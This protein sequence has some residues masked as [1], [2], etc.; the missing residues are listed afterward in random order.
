MGSPAALQ[1]DPS[2]EA[3][4]E[5]EA[6][7]ENSNLHGARPVYQN[8]SMRKWIRTSRLSIKNSLCTPWGRR[9]RCSRNRA[10][11]R[12]ARGRRRTRSTQIRSPAFVSRVSGFGFR[13]SGFGL[14]VSG[15]GFRVS[16][17]GFRVLDF[18]FRL[19]VLW[20]RVSGFGFCVSGF[21]FRVLG[22]EPVGVLAHVVGVHHDQRDVAVLP[23]KVQSQFFLP[24]QGQHLQK[25]L[26]CST[27]NRWP[28]GVEHFASMVHEEDQ[29]DVA[30][31]PEKDDSLITGVPRS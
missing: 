2:A 17:F 22:S 8:I 15:F 6:G 25:W 5:G 28:R 19:S 13:V 3:E 31:L 16:G 11:R 30:V 10:L 7:T 23:G 29:R 20:F 18:G 24:T 21:G 26:I 4:G 1:Q 14:R 12:R 27:N 9:R